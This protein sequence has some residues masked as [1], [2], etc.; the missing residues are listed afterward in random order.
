[1]DSKNSQSVKTELNFSKISDIKLTLHE[2]QIVRG[3]ATIVV[4]MIG[5]AI[6]GPPDKFPATVSA[7]QLLAQVFV[8]PDS[9]PT[10]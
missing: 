9:G 5:K 1:M 3:P 6:R 8:E 4:D 10:F 2:L 7:K